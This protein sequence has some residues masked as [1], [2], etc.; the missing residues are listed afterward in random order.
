ME[1]LPHTT[2]ISLAL[3][4]VVVGLGALLLEPLPPTV[5]LLWALPPL[6]A[7]IGLWITATFA[8]EQGWYGAL[9][10]RVP[11]GFHGAVQVI[12]AL[13]VAGAALWLLRQP[14]A[15]AAPLER[16]LFALQSHC[17]A[18]TERTGRNLLPLLEVVEEALPSQRSGP[19][20]AAEAR[21]ARVQQRCLE[22]TREAFAAPEGTHRSWG[23]LR[24]WLHDHP[25]GLPA[26]D[27]LWTA[28]LRPLEHPVRL[29][30]PEIE[31]AP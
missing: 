27:P 31:L 3:G 9:T 22:R 19:R 13:L 6:G 21:L 30:A 29:E 23:L 8:T 2:W 16:A 4:L 14:N 5:T 11:A 24:D 17:E 1:R 15:Q 7:G 10:A 26:N 20:A 25:H 12:S 28:P 18:T